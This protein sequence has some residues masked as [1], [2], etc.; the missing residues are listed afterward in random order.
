ME[1]KPRALEVTGLME[2]FDV[3]IEVCRA[4]LSKIDA[5][6]AMITAGVQWRQR[7]KNIWN[8]NELRILLDDLRSKGH[9][10]Y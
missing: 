6:L 9:Y 1:Y 4:I 8:E 5:Y 7:V 10:C 3:I 2:R